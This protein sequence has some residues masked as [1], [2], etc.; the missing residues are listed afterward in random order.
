[1][2]EWILIEKLNAKTHVEILYRMN[3]VTTRDAPDNKK[4]QVCGLFAKVTKKAFLL[5]MCLKRHFHKQMFGLFVKVS[6]KAFSQAFNCETKHFRCLIEM[7]LNPFMPTVQTFAVRETDVSRHNGG[8]SG[9]PLKPL[10]VDSVLRALMII[11]FQSNHYV[12]RSQNHL[13]NCS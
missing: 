1:M 7:F 13:N 4:R 5:W 2:H 11:L 10:R 3:C 9:A 6:T 8:T 12:S